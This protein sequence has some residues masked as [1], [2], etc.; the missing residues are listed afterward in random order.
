MTT[1]LT[2]VAWMVLLTWLTIM[3]ASMFR[4]RSWTLEG[5]KL[6]LGNRDSLPAPTPIAGRAE[7]TARN[8]QENFVLFAALALTAHVAGVDGQQVEQGAQI[9][10]WARLVYVPVYIAGIAY[11]R[12]VVWFVG[13]YGLAKIF[14]ALL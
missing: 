10:F 8:T 5:F 6:A 9:F 2:M 7:R 13:L 4:S 14:C 1:T 11:L 12:S 3:L